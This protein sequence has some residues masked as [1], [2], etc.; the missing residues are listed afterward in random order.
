[1]DAQQLNH[2]F[3]QLINQHGISAIAL[4]YLVTRLDRLMRDIRDTLRENGHKLDRL[5]E[6]PKEGK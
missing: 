6:S 1:M 2:Q 5:L 4:V 3:W